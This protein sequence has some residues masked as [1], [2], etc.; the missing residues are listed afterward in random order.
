M[1]EILSMTG[2]PLSRMGAR[3]TCV[4]NAM[5]KQVPPLRSTFNVPWS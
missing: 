3:S 4:L 1:H 5:E 2:Q